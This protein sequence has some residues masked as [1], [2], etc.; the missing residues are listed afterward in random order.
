MTG[1]VDITFA[2]LA[3]PTQSWDALILRSAKQAGCSVLLTEN[4]QDTREVDGMR[5]V[6]PFASLG[7]VPCTGAD[8]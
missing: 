2:A 8:Q 5:I 3:D 6:N 7:R 4:L 1:D